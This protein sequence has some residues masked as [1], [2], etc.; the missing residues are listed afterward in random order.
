MKVH[1]VTSLHRVQASFKKTFLFQ[2][3]PPPAGQDVT[4]WTRWIKSLSRGPSSALTQRANCV[5][6]GV[7]FPTPP[8]GN[9]P[10]TMKR[11]LVFMTSAA[12]GCMGFL[13]FSAPVILT[14]PNHWY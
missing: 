12:Q 13:C 6:G 8:P 1:S 14:G 10:H 9:Q 4:S 2:T 7:W 5:S 3:S 11:T